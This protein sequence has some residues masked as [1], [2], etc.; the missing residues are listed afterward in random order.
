[1]DAFQQQLLNTERSVMV[2]MGA[3]LTYIMMK[4]DSIATVHA[5]CTLV[6]NTVNLS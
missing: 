6:F 3:A 4:S 2:E 5:N 1:M